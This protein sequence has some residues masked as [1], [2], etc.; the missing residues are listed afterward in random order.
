MNGNST[1]SFNSGTTIDDNTAFIREGTDV[2]EGASATLAQ[3]TAN[4]SVG[5]FDDAGGNNDRVYIAW[6]DGTHSYIGLITADQNDDGF[7]GDSLALI[8]TLSG[9]SDCTTLTASN[10]S[11]FT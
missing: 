11:D 10:F 5:T 7:T 6:D 1:S 4:I 9:L 3:A 8:C 2:S